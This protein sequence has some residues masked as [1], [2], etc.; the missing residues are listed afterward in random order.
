[1]VEEDAYFPGGDNAWIRF[2]ST[3]INSMVPV[4][5]G[6]P[7]GTYTVIV[8]FIVTKD[9]SVADIQPL[10]DYGYGMEAEAMRVIAKSPKWIPAVQNKRKVNAYRQRPLT[11]VV[12]EKTRK[13]KG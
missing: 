13:K 7:A 12:E 1:M 3:N 2:L 5:K 8:R 4:K 6:A 11:F 10:T 9:G